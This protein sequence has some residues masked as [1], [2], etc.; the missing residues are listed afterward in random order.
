M[1]DQFHGKVVVITGASSGVGRACARAFAA[2]GASIGLIA[3]SA[4]GL[5]AAAREVS[6]LG[7]VPL[8][9]PA[10]V[11]DA[12]A[13]ERAAAAVEARFGQIDIWVNNAMV[14]VFSPVAE[15]TADEYRRVTEVTYLG[16]VYGT[17]AA[18][19]RMR[20]RNGGTI[21]QVGSALVY[22]SIPLQSAYC[23]AKAAI[24]GFTDALR[25]ELLHDGSAIR[26]SMI[27]LPAVN[28][29][30]FDVVRTRLPGHPQPVPPIYQPEMIADAILYCAEQAPR[31]MLVAGSTIKAVIGQKLIP[32]LLDRYLA[33]VGVAAQ[34][35]NYPVEPGR[36]DNLYEPLPGDRG[37]RGSFGADARVYSP[38]VAARTHPIVT[39]VM[40]AAVV[41]LGAGALAAFRHR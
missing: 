6:E 1:G 18:L 20:P 13:V 28:T 2:Q 31:E 5:A 19:K 27:Q 36:P 10:D 14:S 25:T 22:R 33:R 9:L 15:M 3:R 21:I 24:R 17:L 39:G 40:A 12:G 23:A 8:E 34:Q 7:G 16:Y 37:A 30:Q 11:A 35:A 26:V 41:A 29:P 32:G 38:E 4:D